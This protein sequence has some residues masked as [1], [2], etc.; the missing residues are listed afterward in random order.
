M[1]SIPLKLSG[2]PIWF[3]KDEDEKCRFIGTLENLDLK[4]KEVSNLIVAGPGIT[5]NPTSWVFT[6]PGVNISD[7]S[8]EKIA[9]RVVEIIRTEGLG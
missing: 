5:V 3:E 9:R 1:K 4:K 7:E 6:D 2:K 8:V